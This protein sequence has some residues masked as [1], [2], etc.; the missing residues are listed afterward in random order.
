MLSIQSSKGFAHRQRRAWL[1]GQ[2][3]GSP[4]DQLSSTNGSPPGVQP[5]KISKS[6]GYDSTLVNDADVRAPVPPEIAEP[7]ETRETCEFVA[8]SE[9]LSFFM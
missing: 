2:W 7:V 5:P 4:N 8:N 1:F 3:W 9:Q 6:S